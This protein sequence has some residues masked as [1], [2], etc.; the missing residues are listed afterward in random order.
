MV[1]SQTMEADRRS[2]D[3]VLHYQQST[4]HHQLSHSLR[5]T[6]PSCLRRSSA[7]FGPH[8]P[9]VNVAIGGGLSLLCQAFSMLSMNFQASSTSSRRA[10]RVASPAMPSSKRRS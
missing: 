3:K 4:T 6:W 8:E 2:K 7:S 5:Q 1:D 10:N 9:A